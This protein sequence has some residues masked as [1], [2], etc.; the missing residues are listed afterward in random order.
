MTRTYA[1]RASTGLAVAL[2]TSL[3]IILAG[4]GTRIG[5]TPSGGSAA[6]SGNAA[7]PSG[8]AL[9]ATQR[10]GPQ[11][12]V[13]VTSERLAMTADD[14]A[15]WSDIDPP[16]AAPGSVK[17][18]FFRDASL[19]WAAIFSAD[20]LMFDRTADGGK[21]WSVTPAG[22]YIDGIGQVYFTFVDDTSG[23]ALVTRVSSSNFTVGDLY[24]TQNS[25]KT[26]TKLAVP[27]AGPIRFASSADGWVSG[28]PR[29]DEL[30]GTHDGGTTWKRLTIAPPSLF[31]GSQARY[32]APALLG[33]SAAVLSVTYGGA[34]SGVA[35]FTTS[36]V[37]RT[38]ALK[39]TLPISLTIEPGTNLP[40]ALIDAKT[41]V[42][43]LPQALYE[44][45]DAG[46][47]WTNRPL[48]SD[49]LGINTLV[50]V[51]ALDGWAT[52]FA[53]SCAGEKTDCTTSRALLATHDA[54]GSWV[55][56]SP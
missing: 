50:F 13:A 24:R 25:G 52:R 35:F 46:T 36:D 5:V 53:G 43:A 40:T 12:G 29:G 48:P 22:E 1:D 42:V 56:L 33:G 26:W 54:G 11:V 30:Y 49:A 51:T 23:W 44:T 17:S 38:W 41:W 10:L 45:T 2:L 15:T 21:T 27:T 8:P 3:V 4:C 37:G 7:D 16:E 14:G 28:G 18:A 34:A 31:A 47:S 39:G 32:G 6:G 20:Q 9:I 55:R 19:G